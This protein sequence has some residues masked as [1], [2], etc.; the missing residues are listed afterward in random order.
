MLC[1]WLAGTTPAAEPQFV[2]PHE[3]HRMYETRFGF[4]IKPLHLQVAGVAITPLADYRDLVSS[5]EQGVNKDGW[6]YPPQS[7]Q[8]TFPDPRDMSRY[9]RVPETKRPAHL[10]SLPSSH[11]LC[12]ESPSSLDPREGDASFLVQLLAYLYGTRLQVEDFQFDGKV[13]INQTTHPVWLHQRAIER[14]VT[15]AY[16]EW[17][18]NPPD[19]RLRIINILYM[20]TKAPSYDW[21]WEQFLTEYLVNDALYD[22]CCRSGLA[23]EVAHERRI[24]ELCDRLGVWRAPEAP[25]AALVTMRN[26]LFHEALWEGERPGYRNGADGFYRTADLRTLNQRLIAALLGGRT[27]YTETQWSDYRVQGDFV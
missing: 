11:S 22:L 6:Y 2:R 13:A 20:H 1:G 17:R 18:A 9:E 23:S 4:L 15:K 8:V 3:D 10:F 19:R 27:E 24:L 12:I 14:F 21:T 26:A 5:F 7:E 25:I 16:A